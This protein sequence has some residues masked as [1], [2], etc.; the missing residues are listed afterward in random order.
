MSPPT[1]DRN[2]LFGILSLQIDFI[3][4]DA[5]IAALNA[6]VLEKHRPLGEILVARG[7]LS[8]A[9]RTLLELLVDE[10]VRQHG[11][12]PR[13]CLATLVSADSTR[14][15]LLG[16]DDL[17]VRDSLGHLD[18]DRPPDGPARATD[19][20]G[21][22]PTAPD[23]DPNAT[24]TYVVGP[25]GP[26]PRYRVLRLHAQGGIGSVSVALDSELNRQVALKQIQEPYADHPESRSRFVLEAEITGG[27]EHPGIVPV[28]S[29]G[30]DPNGRPFYAM[31]FVEGD[32]L[33]HAIAR[34]HANADRHDP[35][36]R[37]LEFRQLLRRFLDIC[38]AIAYAHSRGVLHRDMKPGNVMVGRFGETLVVD[39][40]LA[41][42]VGTPE[43]SDEATLRP[44][45]SVGVGQTVAG[46]AVGTPSYMS[47]EQAD[48]RLDLLGPASDVYSLGATLYA[49]LT[50]RPPVEDLDTPSI[51]ERV[52][53]GDFPPPRLVN[54][55]VPPALDALCLKAMALTPTDRYPSPLA[56]AADLEAWLADE[57]VSCYREPPPVRARRWARRHQGLVS[58]AAA[59][60][61]IGFAALA[62]LAVVIT[63][64]NRR[65]DAANFLLATAN[66]E[67]ADANTR[68][69]DQNT[70]LQATNAALDRSRAEALRER[71]QSRVVTEFLITSFRSPD[72]GRDGRTITI[73]EILTRSLDDLRDR[74]ALAPPT[75][76]AILNAIGQ[77]Y[78]GLGLTREAVDVL[79]EARALSAEH[80]GPDHPDTL[81][82][83]NELGMA[84]WDVGRR[85]EAIAMHEATLR[86]WRS[87]LGDDHPETITTRGNLAGA[88][89]DSSRHAEAVP[90]AEANLRAARSAYG[91]DH[92]DTLTSQNTLAFAYQ[93]AGRLDEAAPLLEANL[94]AV[95]LA[96]GDDH[97]VTLTARSN[98]AEA[99]RESGRWDEAIPLLQATLPAMRAA[100]GDDHPDTLRTQS[101]LATAFLSA[102]RWDEAI[103]LLEA[104]LPAMRSKHGDD[105]P[106]TLTARSNLAGAYQQT[107]RWDEAI[108]LLEATL[109]A[110]RAALGDDHF[111][112]MAARNNLATAY[113][114][115]GRSAEA[116]PH[117]EATH[118]ALQSI[119]GDDHP[120]T[121]TALN[122][123]A[124][125][126]QKTDRLDD[127]IA[128]HER[129]LHAARS[130]F[131]DD[132]AHT[133]TSLNNLAGAYMDAARW[134]E[135][136]PFAEANLR[137]A[138]STRGD[139]HP[140]TLRAK[141]NLAEAYRGAG[142]R[143]EAIPLL[144]Q[145]LDGLQTQ[146]G[147]QH[148]WTTRTR[149]NLILALEEAGRHSDAEPLHRDQLDAD[150]RREPADE[151]AYAD[152]LA[153]LGLNLLIQREHA[154]AGPVLRECL[155]LRDRLDPGAWTT[156]N[157]RSMLGEA[158][159]N[160]G[161]FDE[162]EPLL[163]DGRRDL[164]DQADAIPDQVRES[165][166]RESIER[167]VRLY[168]SWGKPEPAARWRREVAA[169]RAEPGLPDDVFAGSEAG[170]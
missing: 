55:D 73:V 104:T 134:D 74:D 119:F 64:S 135:A 77:S 20:T 24:V 144:D 93:N 151:P 116:L 106:V 154:E 130:K 31:R 124:V 67:L 68:I 33:K 141:N 76:A 44:P 139:D 72:P 87:T 9:R 54:P 149:G 41:K 62:A 88:Y 112:T 100:L 157:T 10:H 85:D 35:G 166:R 16:I 158:L 30:H 114:S 122:N 69:L 28:Y 155:E 96:H 51:L 127:A 4:R 84:Y 86:A 140:D 165:R 43:G 148:P 99:Y 71:D 125:T 91:P 143:D 37:I 22:I 48:G 133:L 65:L 34:F 109:Q 19:A 32:S 126:Y 89:A 1:A 75:R 39:W 123:L 58:A 153:M 129:N 81:R 117:F 98:L 90:L 111:N 159:T 101:N 163:L 146:F 23:P 113:A 83:Q 40:G 8:E 50:G 136:I 17:D 170:R 164:E 66:T 46:K 92:P 47:P 26:S 7:D 105:H 97:P 18:V 132:H 156:A 14:T 137:A 82:S 78:R 102:H 29:L 6:W 118:R 168:E 12:D 60:F 53:R 42:V 70:Q 167:L 5:L 15:V 52:R 169:L 3:T 160:L 121:M 108:P 145:A 138:R 13:R 45:S 59:A 142:R 115:S 11:G 61:V 152:A 107:G 56:L 63:S 27:L 162:A 161:Q 110:M 147:A 79:E 120:T 38:Q 95:R 25:D 49:L 128:L 57:P 150:G 21:S 80:L 94:E 103:P 2:L 131:G 36:R